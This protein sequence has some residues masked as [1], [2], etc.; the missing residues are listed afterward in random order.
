VLGQLSS[1][2]SSPLISSWPSKQGPGYDVALLSKGNT[3]AKDMIQTGQTTNNI[4]TWVK[5]IGGWLIMFFGFGMITQIISTAA[6]ISIRWIPLL[7]PMAAS[8][9]DLGVSIANVVLASTTSF[10]VAGIS[11]LFYRPVM[12]FTLLSVSGTVFYLASKY[13]NKNNDNNKNNN[14]RFQETPSRKYTKK[15]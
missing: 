9:I 6:D 13:G 11:W 2:S 7:G 14:N 8:I 3:T 15:I 5:R 1:S 10:L 4:W 12:G